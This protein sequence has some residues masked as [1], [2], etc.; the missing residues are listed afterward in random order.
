M[1]GDAPQFYRGEEPSQ[2][3]SDPAYASG[4]AVLD[5]QPWVNPGLIYCKNI[6]FRGASKATYSVLTSKYVLDS[7]LF[8]NPCFDFLINLVTH[9]AEL[10]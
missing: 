4:T 7:S 1:E 2:A 5:D 8:S 9:L 10:C 3:K 6:H